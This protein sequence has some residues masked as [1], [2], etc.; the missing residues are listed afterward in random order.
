MLISDVETLGERKSPG[1]YIL[2]IHAIELALKSFLLDNEISEKDLRK[3]YGHKL[4][5]LLNKANDLGLVVETENAADIIAR[6]DKHTTK[7]M[8]RYNL[9]FEMPLI[10]DI[11]EVAKSLLK[12]LE[13]PA[14]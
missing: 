8:I 6:L 11:I 5:S 1:Q 4:T 10:S 12:A 3:K 7:P 13:R 9:K 2:A 14:S